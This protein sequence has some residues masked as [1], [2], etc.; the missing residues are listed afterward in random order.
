MVGFLRGREN[1]RRGCVAC[2]TVYYLFYCI[3]VVCCRGN[4]PEPLGL[5]VAIMDRIEQFPIPRIALICMMSRMPAI[6]LHLP[7]TS[8]TAAR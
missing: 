5:L 6:D 7:M 1:R 8:L 2:F 3:L 4:V